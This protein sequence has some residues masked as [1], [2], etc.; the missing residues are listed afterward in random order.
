MN[1]NES[2]TMS[3]VTMI[4]LIISIVLTVI[5]LL[6]FKNGVVIIKD[7]EIHIDNR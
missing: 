6:A 1:N 2:G 7:A 5:N 4:M 3:V